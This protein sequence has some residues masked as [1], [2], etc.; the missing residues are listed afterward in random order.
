METTQVALE[1]AVAISLDAVANMDGA[2]LSA[3][4]PADVDAVTA[5]NKSTPQAVPA[6]AAVSFSSITTSDAVSD[7]VLNRNA[8]S[9]ADSINEQLTTWAGVINGVVADGGSDAAAQV[10]E[11]N[12]KIELLRSAVNAAMN[13]IRTANV[14]QNSDISTAVNARL[15]TVAG[16][17]TSLQTAIESVD[18]KIVALDSVYG[19][20]ADIAGKVATI[21]AQLETMNASDLDIAGLLGN[22]TVEL[23]SLIRIQKQEVTVS[24]GTGVFD[25]NFDAQGIGAFDT[26]ADYTVAMEI[27]GNAQVG[28]Y[29]TNKS[30]A[31]FQIILRSQGVHFVPQPHDGATT[32]V[33]VAVTV[34]HAPR[35]AS[36]VSV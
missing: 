29:I 8:T 18:G 10:T 6:P 22:T 36:Q 30:A 12:N 11:F 31:G 28:G 13:D 2:A 24:A 17:L 20:D 1:T 35:A 33:T 16:N 14:S 27:I 26:V 21:N 23:D 5:E 9:L 19:T 3:P 32:P 4:A 15:S 7:E 34:A 25:F